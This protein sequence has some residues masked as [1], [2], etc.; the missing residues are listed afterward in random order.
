MEDARLRGGVSR[1]EAGINIDDGIQFLWQEQVAGACV[2]SVSPF[3]LMNV[4]FDILCFVVT[5]VLMEDD[6]VVDERAI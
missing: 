5:E 3:N 4:H 2:G 1:D 6:G